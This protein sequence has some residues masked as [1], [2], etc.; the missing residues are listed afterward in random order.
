MGTR[1]ASL[2]NGSKLYKW[3]R[4]LQIR[5]HSSCS[6]GKTPLALRWETLLPFTPCW[7]LMLVFLI[8]M[9][10]AGLENTN[11]GNCSKGQ[12]IMPWNRCQWGRNLLK[13]KGR[14]DQKGWG[15][16]KQSNFSWLKWVT[17][18][19]RERGLAVL[20]ALP[21]CLLP[22]FTAG[23][24]HIQQH[25]GENTSDSGYVQTERQMVPS[26]RRYLRLNFA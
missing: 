13:E 25:L 24:L 17:H 7:L 2:N 6:H 18:L 20:R 16:E 8:H 26:L 14:S 1:W 4:N 3:E 23:H 21:R 12:F 5:I 11:C 19:D 22:A 15:V 9:L 10:Q